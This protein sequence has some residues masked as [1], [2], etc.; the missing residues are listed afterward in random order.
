MANSVIYLDHAA[1]TEAAPAVCAVM[2]HA[3]QLAYGN[4]SSRH[5]LGVAGRALMDTARGQVARA[6]GAEREDVI[7]TSGGTEANNL[8]VVGAAFNPTFTA[9]AGDEAH[10]LIGPTEHASVRACAAPLRAAGLRVET[11][12]LNPQGHL[13]IDHVAT[14]I[15]PNTRVV[16]Q[17]LVNNEFG[18]RYDVTRLARA[19]AARGG[20]R[21]HL[22]IDAVQAFGKLPVDVTTLFESHRLS[23]SVGLSAHKVLGPKGSGALVLARGSVRPQPLLFGGGQETGARPGTEN[24]PAIAGFGVAAEM[25]STDL[26]QRFAKLVAVRRAFESALAE[27]APELHVLVPYVD[28]LSNSP[29]VLSLQVPGAPSEVWLHHLEERGVFV[30]AGS[31]CQAQ[32]KE[33]SPALLALG[34]DHESA[35]RVL[36]VSFATSTTVDDCNT[37]VDQLAALVPLLATLAAP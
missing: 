35:R 29:H 4:P 31:A 16:A 23:G 5:P 34:L 1:T 32:S 12:R 26:D 25:V 17:M 36:R 8:G 3:L 37:A 6:T 10:V 21:T 19:V 18:T 13:D 22:H 28:A 7:F 11:M 2:V 14:R 27:R 30:S 24:V 9:L 15:G 20:P 33:I